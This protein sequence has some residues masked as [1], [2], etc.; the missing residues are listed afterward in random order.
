[1]NHLH[2]LLSVDTKVI[3][4]DEYSNVLYINPLFMVKNSLKY[5]EQRDKASNLMSNGE[6]APVIPLHI[7]R[8]A[9]R[10][11]ETNTGTDKKAYC[12][13]QYIVVDELPSELITALMKIA[14][15]CVIKSKRVSRDETPDFVQNCLL[16]LLVQIEQERVVCTHDKTQYFIIKQDGDLLEIE[17]WFGTA[18]TN[19]SIDRY[20]RLKNQVDNIEVAGEA[21]SS[22]E[23]SFSIFAPEPSTNLE[24][25]LR[26][27]KIQEMAQYCAEALD[28]CMADTWLSISQDNYKNFSLEFNDNAT[29]TD[30]GIAVANYCQIILEDKYHNDGKRIVRHDSVCEDLGMI[31]RPENIS[32]KKKKFE[33]LMMQCIANKVDAEFGDAT[34]DILQDSSSEEV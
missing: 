25:D 23:H 12:K 13:N 21:R 14:E 24:D 4:H 2:E 31:I 29:T 26:N 28:D 7:D 20:R 34:K 10:N 16:K 1:M 22:D 15:T 8:N 11:V 32:H 5:L 9:E 33:Q 17:R 19:I 6:K 30:K 3:P 18:A 27:N